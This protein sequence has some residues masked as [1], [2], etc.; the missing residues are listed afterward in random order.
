MGKVEQD[1]AIRADASADIGTGH[2]MRC[3]T[4]ADALKGRGG[5][6]RFLSRHITDHLRRAVSDRGHELVE[7]DSPARPPGKNVLSH[8][9]WLGSDQEGDAAETV[10]ALSDRRWG[11]VIVDS[12]AL[13][14]TW[15][16]LVRGSAERIC[17]I[18]D[19]ADRRHEC[20]VLL[21]QNVHGNINIKYESLVPPGCTLLLGPRYAMLRD[22]F[23]R[24]RAGV[25]PRDGTVNR[26]FVLIGGIDA[27]NFTATAVEALSRMTDRGLAVDV[28]VGAQHPQRAALERRARN[29]GYGFH[30]QT[31][32]VAD[33]M[34]AADLA[35]GAS[36]A[37]SWER[38]CLGLPALVVTLAA[39]QV[40]IARGL[41]EL[42]AAIYLG[43]D[44]AV[45]VDEVHAAISSL[46]AD[47]G[48]VREMSEK[49]FALVDGEGVRRV[50]DALGVQ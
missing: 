29:A 21:D 5:S 32:E 26:I 8:S 48:R 10:A 4:L 20:E 36:G 50:C 3:L 12:Y 14:A 38:C 2:Y 16:R 42:G 23:R 15:E 17:V 37:T 40:S 44:D 9:H 39:N 47:G 1:V 49:A 30:V 31:E 11:W 18:D 28:V 22:E 13:D 43:P 45:T 27:G 25:G 41:H 33:L 19:I 34:A 7:F 24:L 35:I 6:V 46:L